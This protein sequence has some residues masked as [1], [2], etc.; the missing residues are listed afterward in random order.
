MT[1]AIEQQ[2]QTALRSVDALR[3]R[4]TELKAAAANQNGAQNFN[5]ANLAAQGQDVVVT[6]FM[7]MDPLMI[8][9]QQGTQVASVIATMEKP[10]AGL[11]AAFMS[12]VSPVSLV[13]VGLVAG[14]AALIQYFTTSDEGT[15]G[16]SADLAKQADLI[17]NLAKQWGEA[18]PALKA[19]ADEL[20]RAKDAAELSAG[21]ELLN[22][23]TL[24]D[25]ASG[26]SDAR[27]SI[28]ELVTQLQAAG[29]ENEVI[30]NLQNA[31]DTFANAA[32]DGS[33]KLEDVTTVQNA[34]IAATN[35]SGIPAI[36][37]FTTMFEKLSTA[38]MGAAGSVQSVNEQAIAAAAITSRYPSQGAYDGLIRSPEFT[39]GGSGTILPDNGP[40]PRPRPSELDGDPDEG[41]SRVLNS[42]GYLVDVPVPKR[43]PNDFE[44]DEGN[45]STARSQEQRARSLDTLLEKQRLELDLVGKSAVEQERLRMQFQLTTQLKEEAARTGLPIDQAELARIGEKSAAYAELAQK[46][47][48]QKAIATQD[49][50]IERLRAEIDL[51]GQSTSA[52]ADNLR[53]LDTER[54]I[55]D[56]GIERNSVEAEQ[57]REKARLTGELTTELNR[58]KEAWDM[59]RSASDS[60]IDNMFGSLIKGD[61]KGALKG[62]LGDVGKFFQEL[63]TNSIKNMVLGGDRTELSDVIA[64]FTRSAP[65]AANQNTPSAGFPSYAA[66]V[67]A[68][69]RSA[70]PTS[71][72]GNAVDLASNLLGFSETGQRGNIN[73]F[74]RAGGVN[75]DAAQT[76]WCAGFVNSSLEQIGVKGSGSL[77]ANSFQNWGQRVDLASVLKGDVLVD[78]NG[79]GANQPG[80]HVGFA[81][82]ASRMG[83]SGL[84]LEML[85][86]NSSNQVNKTWVNAMELQ[87]RRATE[88]ATNVG[89][90]AN[91]STT[92]VQGL[93]NLGNGLG[94]F[95]QQLLSASSGANSPSS[96]LGSLGS[97]LGGINPTSMFWAPNTTLGSFL[98]NGYDVGGHTG[99]GPRDSIA[100]FVHGQEFVVKASVVAQPGVRR[101]LE[102]LNSGSGYD[103]GGFVTRIGAPASI[104]PS[105]A[106]ER[107]AA[108]ANDRAGSGKSEINVYV[109]NPR[110]DRDIEDAVDRGVAKGLRAYDKNL[111]ARFDQIK[112]R[113]YVRGQ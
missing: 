66:P 69:T 17:G 53:I 98:T 105:Q 59:V 33:L 100:G 40:T 54:K 67:G 72:T 43:R 26:V 57:M 28:S 8:G 12:L 16:M 97:L 60:A 112:K 3:T 47:A 52:R 82:G 61:F 88:A 22:K 56:L 6:A 71:G 84:Q 99:N 45:A 90:L 20:G 15:G 41:D 58:Q 91:A 55:R 62:L 50:E 5:T 83:A 94:Q 77:T 107:Q 38:A 79:Y 74:L 75:I 51:V 113:P 70:L 76:A 110:G 101:L 13:T 2:R 109:D 104:Y 39:P 21:I 73:S 48:A 10:V 23:D 111:P 24:K 4:N 34:L 18:I 64:R 92:A 42:D 68:V 9:L 102:G 35:D 29:A 78:T 7:G 108:V 1:A 31:F 95:S 32:A 89:S 87:A 46:I 65:V 14:T 44:R 96:L 19:Y 103:Q 11:A 25:V 106:Q 37:A 63:G 27:I 49:T 30:I 93:G 85:S 86:G 36:A 81:T 80:G